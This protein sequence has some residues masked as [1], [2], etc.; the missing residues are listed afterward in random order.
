VQREGGPA[1]AY[2]KIGSCVASGFVYV[3]A[4]SQSREAVIHFFRDMVR[5]GLVEFYNRWN[6]VVDQ[7]GWSFLVADNSDLPSRGMHTS[8]LA[9]ETTLTKLSRYGLTL[10]FLPFQ[11]YPRIGNWA[12]LRSTAAIHHLT[13]DGSLGPQYDKPWGVLPFRGHRQRLDRYDEIDFAEYV[14]V[15]RAVGLWRVAEAS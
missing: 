10:A 8:Q 14:K 11:S 2:R 13:A 3:R 7:M 9:N 1:A 4:R 15:M 6:N 5:R 12:E